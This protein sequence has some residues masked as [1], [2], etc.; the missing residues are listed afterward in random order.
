MALFFQKAPPR[1][2]ADLP[3]AEPLEQRYP[4]A[5]SVLIRISREGWVG[6]RVA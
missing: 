3:A 2:G 1:Q 6:W 5:A 4:P